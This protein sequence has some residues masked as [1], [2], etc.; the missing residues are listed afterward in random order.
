MNTIKAWRLIGVPNLFFGKREPSFCGIVIWKN[1]FE[2]NSGI[3]NIYKQNFVKNHGRKSEMGL[4]TSGNS[5]I[6]GS[7]GCPH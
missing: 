5:G 3:G 1:V 4:K 7:I 2:R 6:S